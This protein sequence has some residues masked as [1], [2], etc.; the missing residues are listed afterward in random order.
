MISD[1][2]YGEDQRRC[3]LGSSEL[4]TSVHPEQLLL[5][6]FAVA[7]VQSMV[8]DEMDDGEVSRRVDGRCQSR[9]S[10]KWA[11]QR[12][13]W[14]NSWKIR[15][16]GVSFLLLRIWVAMRKG[17]VSLFPVIGQWWQAVEVS[18]ARRRHFGVWVDRE[19]KSEGDEIWGMREMLDLRSLG[20]K[21]VLGCVWTALA[22]R[23]W[24]L[25]TSCGLLKKRGIR[26]WAASF[27]FEFV[28][29]SI[30][31]KKKEETCCCLGN[32]V[33]CF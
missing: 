7:P 2:A 33:G 29:C 31:V 32:H 10:L 14:E 3:K 19:G 27:F 15:K 11:D 13:V 25:S 24:R 6:L 21:W 18:L 22:R 20:I 23:V 28:Y 26:K 1:E 16:K 12:W 8:F 9:W 4:Q 17:I 5:L 30:T